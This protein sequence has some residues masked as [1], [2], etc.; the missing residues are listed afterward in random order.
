MAALSHDA[1][2]PLNAVFLAA[3]LLE[4]PGS[5]ARTSEPEVQESLRVIRDSVRNVLD[6]LSDLLDLSR[7]DAGASPPEISRFAL[8][9]TLAECLSSIEPQAHR[10]KG[11]TSSSSPTASPASTSPT[12]RNKLKQIL[13]NLLSNALGY[14]EGGHIR[15]FGHRTADRLTISVEDT[16]IGI[17]PRS[18]QK[19]I[20]DGVRHP[21]PPAARQSGRDGP[22]PGDLPAPRRAPP[23][24]RDPPGEQTQPRQHVHARPAD[25]LACSSMPRPTPTCRRWPSPRPA[26]RS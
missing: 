20:F 18:D 9:S 26:A 16:G 14:T 12:D 23:V 22:R 21:R 8:E 7:I 2:T 3:Q 13:A 6:L 1:R 15:L 24:R 25:R 17:A 10:A 19:R 4:V 11:W 5:T